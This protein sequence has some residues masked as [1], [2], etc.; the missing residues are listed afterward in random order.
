MKTGMLAELG[1]DPM[2][3]KLADHSATT[4]QIARILIE[5][6]IKHGFDP[7]PFDEGEPGE[8]ILLGDEALRYIESTL[9][10]RTILWTENGFEMIQKGA[11]YMATEKNTPLR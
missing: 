4:K 6:A 3:L 8:L 11:N 2:V 7:F 1:G 10:D 5:E 9:P